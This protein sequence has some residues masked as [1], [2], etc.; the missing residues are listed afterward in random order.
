[1]KAKIRKLLDELAALLK[2]QEPGTADRAI[3]QIKAEERIAKDER[4]N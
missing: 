3:E 4:I 2:R 1:M